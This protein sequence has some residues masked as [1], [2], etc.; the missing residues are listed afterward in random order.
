MPDALIVGAGP[1]GLSA[2]LALSTRGVSV[3]VFEQHAEPPPRVCG[4]FVN[5]E[6]TSH[7]EMLGVLDGLRAAGAVPVTTARLEAAG[8]RKVDVPI[9]RGGRSGLAVPR[10]ILE[11]VMADNV[12]RRGGVIRWA[13]RIT[14]GYRD[15]RTWCVDVR[16]GTEASAHRAPLL[17][18]ADGRFSSLSGRRTASARHGWFGWNA[19]WAGVDQ[20]PGHLSLYFHRSGYVGALVFGDGLTNVCGLTRRRSGGS[21]SW[22]DACGQAVDANPALA[23][24]LRGANRISPYRGVGP[25]PFSS[26]M[27]HGGGPLVAG[28]AAAV[29]DPYMGEGISRALGTGP[30]LLASLRSGDEIADSVIRPPYDRIWQQRY[31]SRLWLG[32][33][34]RTA[35]ANPRAMA[36]AVGVAPPAWLRWL[37]AVAHRS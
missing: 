21:A 11:R 13:S 36:A 19:T 14:R 15:G 2:A 5:P 34:A 4:A 33:A 26:G 12:V 7:L 22:E 29:G 25:L 28:D 24:L 32:T 35:L 37:G 17:I 1:A 30:V 10:P 18:A 3:C 8:G 9:D 31:R 16:N 20:P 23:R 6:G 27:W